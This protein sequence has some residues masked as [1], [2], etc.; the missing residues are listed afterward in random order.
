MCGIFGAVAESNITPLL[1]DGL[2]R[3]EY[4]GYDS[5]GIAVLNGTIQRARQPGRV[6]ELAQVLKKQPIAGNVGIAHTRW[7]THGVPDKVNAHPHV[8]EDRI[9]I[10]H[11]GVIE[12]YRELR[13][14][15]IDMGFVL[16]SDT[17]T[18]VIAHQI[19]LH[20][21]K[22]MDLLKAVWLS[23]CDLIGSYALGVLDITMPDRIIAVRNGS[24]LLLGIGDN[25]SY[26]SSDM[27][28][29]LAATDRFVP[30][31]NN[32]IAVVTQNKVTLYNKELEPKNYT[33]QTATPQIKN[34][35]LGNYP[36]YMLKEIY[37][38]PQVAEN[39]LEGRLFNDI[40]PCEVFGPHAADILPR[41][42]NIQVVACGSSYHAAMTG[43]YWFEAIAGIPCQVEIASEF[44]YRAHLP[45]PDSLLVTISQSGETADTLAAHTWAMQGDYLAS[46]AICNVPQSSLVRE[47]DLVLLTHA[48]P[49]IGVASTKAF[50]AQL[51]AQLLLVAAI[52]K[53]KNKDNMSELLAQLRNLPTRLEHLF[54]LED[55][56]Q[57]M[58]AK[59]ADKPHM[60]FLGRGPHYPI[61]LE[62]AL[63]MKEITYIHA[64]GYPAGELKHGPL[65]L[66]DKDMPVIAV[67]P[68]D[69]LLHKL[70]TNLLEVNARGG[71]LHVFADKH[72]GFQS[73]D[74]ATLIR[75]DAPENAVAPIVFNIPLQLLAY[76]VAEIKGTNVDRP[77]NLAKS[78]TVE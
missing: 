68:N 7:A 6:A 28:A 49:E 23:S 54:A 46:L 58:A 50:T 37:E 41:V 36:H 24:P 43:K 60:L 8:S 4:R 69:P 77:R 19:I 47:S 71:Q 74:V 44:R 12:N 59:I 9:A 13:Q 11:N 56:I 30:M 21:R 31:E 39:I 63:K 42:R 78:V 25:G 62:G 55:T 73:D 17:D 1:L 35:T 53:H 66:V 61:A 72:S 45:L 14:Q 70:K 33:V 32:E 57:E 48:G 22:E 18:E 26:I 67:A 34:S 3:L 15:Q 76:H 2:H 27:H 65:A 5:A 10:V 75:L 38:Q 16:A 64:E 51:I 52:G 29:L 20:L 40:I